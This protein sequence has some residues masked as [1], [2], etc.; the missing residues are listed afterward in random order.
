MVAPPKLTR[1]P[2]GTAV[3][4]YLGAVRAQATVG[5]LSVR[6]AENYARDLHDFTRL[7]GEITI[8]DDITGPDIDHTIVAFAGAPD[9]R[10]SD[11]AAKD[12]PGRGVGTQKRFRQSLSR[13]FAVAARDGWVQAN[14]M[15]WSDLTPTERGGLR[16]AR[17]AL[18]MEQA[19]ALLTF[20]PGSPDDPKARSWERNHARDQYL[21]AL[22]LL[23]GPRVSEVCAANVD[24]FF[25]SDGVCQWRILGKGGKERQVPLSD[26]LLERRDA[27][28]AGPRPVPGPTVSDKVRADAAKAVFV[29]GRGA[30][31]NPR[32]VQR[33]LSRARLRVLTDAPGL[34][35]EVTP[36]ALR[37]TAATLLLSSG[38]DVKVVQQLLGHASIATTGK[39]LDKVPGELARAIAS[40]PLTP[41]PA[42]VVSD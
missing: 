6:T 25:I 26:Y 5:R 42:H 32:D 14:P 41:K 7:A 8:V 30:R 37:H 18:T 9:G 34:D 11:P 23:L 12:G 24:D 1:I 20:G 38:W 33:F 19:E 4:T 13:F 15:Q 27:Y 40:H 39:Y 36:H 29:T 31:L 3:D 22:L 10:F 17:T 2:L 21:L 28:L 16:S 35:R